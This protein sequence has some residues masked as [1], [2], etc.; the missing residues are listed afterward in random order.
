MPL[1]KRAKK[2]SLT[3]TKKRAPSEKRSG[4][5]ESVRSLIEAR[6]SVFALRIGDTT[7]ATQFKA[8]RAALPAGSRLFLGKKSLMAVALGR[9][10]E[11][12]IRPGLHLV[13][14]R[15]ESSQNA[16]LV[17]T[18]E[19]REAIERVLE[20]SQTAEFAAAGFVAPS[21]LLLEKG[22]LPKFPT[23]MVE[24]LRKLGLQVE[25][26]DAAL[27]L[28]DDFQA[29]SAGKPLSP[30]QAKLLKHLGVKM[31]TFAPE[32]VCGWVDGDFSN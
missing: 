13:S 4:Y 2:V 24:T 32:I 23:S 30:E 29:A 12:E 10:P 27:E 7:R 1:S 18:D 21:S 11:E 26:K 31:D 3:K 8:L 14:K 5:V 6:S 28:I 19:A 17:A 22:P 9:T 15:L 25:V 20:A 16:A